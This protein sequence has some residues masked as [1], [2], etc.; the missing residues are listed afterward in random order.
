MEW[1]VTALFSMLGFDYKNKRRKDRE[2]LEKFLNIL[3]SDGDSVLFLKKHDMGFAARFDYFKSLNRVRERWLAA[4]RK[5]QVA[6][7]EKLKVSFIEKLD[8]FLS[9]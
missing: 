1:L 7:I 2:L 5:F 3:P 9:A 4:D 6:K 8:E